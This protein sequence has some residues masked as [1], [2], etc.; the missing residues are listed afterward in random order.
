MKRSLK[1][2]LP[3]LLVIVVICSISWYLLVYDRDFTRDV[4]LYHARVQE[5]KGNHAVA[6]WF[7]KMAYRQSDD[8]AAVAIELADQF[9]SIG[10]YTK[11]EVTLSDAIA[12]SPSVELYI[13]LSKTYVEQ[14][15]LLDAVRML[16]NVS[17]ESIKAQLEAL[18]PQM[19][20]TDTPPG[21]YNQYMNITI[22]A[23]SGSLYVTQDGTY[24]STDD[25]PH[26]EPITLT[27]GENTIFAL[28][29][30]KNGL[31]SPLA[32]FGYT[33]GGV[34]EEVNFA[35]SEVDALIRQ[36]LGV[37]TDTQ[38]Y[39]DDL[40]EIESFSVPAAV[41]DYSFL[42]YLPG[43]KNLIIMNGSFESLSPI[44][45]LSQ[46]ETIYIQ[47]CSLTSQDMKAISALPK[48]ENLTITG[49]QLSTVE[50]LSGARNLQNLNLSNNAI[51]D[52]TPLSFMTG[53]KSLD[54]SHNALT[55]LSGLSTLAS[56]E[57][58]N[59]SYNSIASIIPISTCVS[60]KE[61]NLSNNMLDSI[62]SVE[63]FKALTY[64]SAS[65]NQLINVTAVSNCTALT[66]LDLGSNQL[67]DISCLSTL[68]NLQE[69]DFSHNQIATMPAWDVTVPLT[70]INGSYNVLHT[71]SGLVGNYTI[72]K[73]VLDYNNITVVNSLKDCPALVSVSVYG[74]P[75][76]NI[77]ALA[78]NNI[79]VYYNPM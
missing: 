30:G 62:A 57:K 13:A 32:I 15:K 44:S 33:V 75:V 8:N 76:S 25:Q 37:D 54:L 10:N 65:F 42:S 61:L 79:I 58:L 77:A 11:A 69:F 4:F 6:A 71:V 59:V 16:E 20:G 17:D 12:N 52:L 22:S 49:C 67:T 23:S 70:Y 64:L 40:W 39:T 72:N 34:I 68:V 21:F 28:S 27:K 29:V 35:D 74:N 1:R 51:R 26:Y 31:V 24:P 73:I 2:I 41:T 53:L 36:Q 46:L 43:L 5:D 18:R 56:L 78:A 19:P 14:D 50:H 55:N 9:K 38:L 66:V 3:I 63:N 60:L 45:V 7:Y 48:L 47:S